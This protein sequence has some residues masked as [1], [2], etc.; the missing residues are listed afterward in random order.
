MVIRVTKDG[1]VLNKQYIN[2]PNSSVGERNRFNEIFQKSGEIRNP[3]F[4]ER[5]VQ[6]Q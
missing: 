5:V 3:E 1:T 2:H 4:S 6:N